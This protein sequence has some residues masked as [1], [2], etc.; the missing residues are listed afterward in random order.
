MQMILPAQCMENATNQR[1]VTGPRFEQLRQGME[2]WH[3][4][5]KLNQSLEMGLNTRHPPPQ[6]NPSTQDWNL[7]PTPL[8]QINP[9]MSR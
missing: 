3:L 1:C 4:R 8:C 6:M 2:T 7:G 5:T 9:L